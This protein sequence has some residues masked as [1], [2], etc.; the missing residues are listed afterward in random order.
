MKNIKLKLKARLQACR[1]AEVNQKERGCEET[2]RD[3][4]SMDYVGTDL[5]WRGPINQEVKE[6]K[7]GFQNVLMGI[8]QDQQG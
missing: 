1:C 3:R 5:A 2:F 4:H 6:S 8:F 7:K